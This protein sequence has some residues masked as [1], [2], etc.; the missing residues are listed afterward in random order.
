MGSPARGPRSAGFFLLSKRFAAAR[1]RSGTKVTIAFTCGLTRS[2]CATKAFTTSVAETLRARSICA[3]L[4][5]G[6]KH[7]SLTIASSFPLHVRQHDGG[8]DLALGDAPVLAQQA[9][10]LGP[11]ERPVAVLLVEADRPGRGAPGADQ[12]RLRG[13]AFEVLQQLL[14]DALAPLRRAH[15]GMPDERD[16][17]A[18]LDAHDA[19]KRAARRASRVSSDPA[20]P[21][22]DALAQ[23]LLHLV[24]RPVGPRPP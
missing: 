14:A 20:A 22:R 12:D 6:V 21:E 19:G 5:A 3:S 2:I 15:V 1:A 9:L 24:A 4:R 17:A 18:V 13:D 16:F 23:R 7:S 8:F 11:G 10:R